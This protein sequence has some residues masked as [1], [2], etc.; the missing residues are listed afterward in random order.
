MST[1]PTPAPA[2]KP[3]TARRFGSIDFQ[4][5][6]DFALAGAIGALF[7]LYLDVELVRA[8]AVWIR[9]AWA[10]LAI[11]GASGYCLNAAAAARDGAWLRAARDAGRGG[12]AGAIGG[13]LGLVAG[14]GMLG[15]LQGG[16]LGRAVSWGILGCAIGAGL[17]LAGRSRPGLVH[18]VLGGLV[19]GFV[20]G[21]LFEAIR[22]RMGD[23]YD[24]G[25]GVGIVLLGA[26]LGLALAL[27][28]QT[29][30]RAWVRVVRGRQEG[31]D[32]SLTR[33]RNALGLDEK[34][35][36]GLFGDATVARRHAEIVVEGRDYVLVVLDPQRRS[37]INGQK[38]VGR[39]ILRD[40]DSI[41]LGQTALLFR[42][43]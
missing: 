37:L 36:V 16:F 24:L 1:T 32:Y 43:R 21:F 30:R 34:A 22:L 15:W 20:G 40:G 27:V 38:V 7:G 19:G 35:E 18:G 11:G 9:D 33:S 14:E 39:P 12:I 23:R 2:L 28:E 17:G 3:P 25:Q 6:S 8:D 4:R 26:G 42:R 13:A 29:L 31:R 10:G 41:E 5:A